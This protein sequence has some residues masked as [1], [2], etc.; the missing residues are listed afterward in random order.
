MFISF[1][2]A[3]KTLSPLVEINRILY[4]QKE[5]ALLARKLKDVESPIQDMQPR[6]RPQMRQRLT[7][8]S[9]SK[10]IK[11]WET[12]TVNRRWMVYME[13]LAQIFTLLVK[14][15]LIV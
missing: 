5:D 10:V 15:K 9:P 6:W 11:K 14:V 4:R 1:T 12:S 8:S 2:K 7:K 3:A 13:V